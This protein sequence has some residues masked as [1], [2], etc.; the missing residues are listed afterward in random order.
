MWRTKKGKGLLKFRSGRVWTLGVLKEG[1]KNLFI[2]NLECNSRFKLFAF[3]IPPND[4]MR[5]LSGEKAQRN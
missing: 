5:N 1:P 3:R 4:K 2:R